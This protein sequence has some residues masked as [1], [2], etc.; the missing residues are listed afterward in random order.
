[1]PVLS[2]K[3][4]EEFLV[5]ENFEQQLKTLV[6]NIQKKY[7]DTYIGDNTHVAYDG[8]WNSIM[9]TAEDICADEQ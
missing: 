2:D 7:V 3:H 9:K 4:L 8:I 5:K 6:S 1:M